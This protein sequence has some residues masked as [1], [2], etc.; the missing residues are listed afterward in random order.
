MLPTFRI[1]SF[2][3]GRRMSISWCPYLT[4]ITIISGGSSL[5][6]KNSTERQ[7]FPQLLTDWFSLWLKSPNARQQFPQLF[8]VGLAFDLSQNA[9]QLA[10]STVIGGWP[11]VWLKSPIT[12][13]RFPQLIAVGLAFNWKIELQCSSCSFSR[14]LRQTV[15]MVIAFLQLYHKPLRE[16]GE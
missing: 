8:K 10:V 2:W 4:P 7:Q 5:Q 9:R 11:S 12:R 6:L 15:T 13:Q 14:L 1:D 16:W 3:R